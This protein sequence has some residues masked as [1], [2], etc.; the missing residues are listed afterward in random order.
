[1]MLGDV[2]D[3][4]NFRQLRSESQSVFQVGEQPR[5]GRVHP[6]QYLDKMWFNFRTCWTSSTGTKTIPDR[7][8]KK[9]QTSSC[10]KSDA[11]SAEIVKFGK[12][13]P[14]GKLT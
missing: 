7:K 1:M 8:F 10:S 4:Q 9:K 13:L 14:S 6:V 2:W 12:W 11:K 5:E 3:S